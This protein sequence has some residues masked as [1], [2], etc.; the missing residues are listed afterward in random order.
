MKIEKHEVETFSLEYK[1]TYG[2]KNAIVS[3]TKWW[4]GEGCD[5][6]ISSNNLNISFSTIH[7]NIEAFIALYNGM[8]IEGADD[9]EA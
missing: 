4:N 2:D 3:I 9:D 6:T 8:N 7:E 1:T 5:V